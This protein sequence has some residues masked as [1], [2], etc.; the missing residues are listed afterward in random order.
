MAENYPGDFDGFH[1]FLRF[2]DGCRHYLADRG[3]ISAEDSATIA[4][5]LR[6]RY[7]VPS[8]DLIKKIYYMAYPDL[9][10][11]K[12]E[13]NRR[14][15]FERGAVRR[16]CLIDHN[17]RKHKEG[18]LVCITYPGRVVEAKKRTRPFGKDKSILEE[19]N[20]V[21][22]SLEPI[23]GIVTVNTD[24]DLK[25]GDYVMVHRLKVIEKLPKVWYDRTIQHLT[26]LGLNKEF[27]FP[28]TAMKYLEKLDGKGDV[29]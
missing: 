15:I 11:I 3:V 25:A 28:K 20:E 4:E 2:A 26:E 12:E 6:N 24:L 23:T 13:E 10:R 5:Y 17:T 8:E 7:E 29:M 16:F 18:N 27:K 21:R 9:T 19:V 14:S 22:I 1:L